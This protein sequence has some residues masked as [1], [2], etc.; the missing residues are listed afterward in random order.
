[1]V[2]GPSQENDFA[3]HSSETASGGNGDG[4]KELIL[5]DDHSTNLIQNRRILDPTEIVNEDR[6]VGRS[7]QLKTVTQA[8]RVVIQNEPPRN[9]YLYGPSGTG[10]SLIL[11]AVCKNIDELCASRDIRFGVLS[12][13][14]QNVGTLSTVVYELILKVAEDTG[15]TIEIPE[16]GIPTKKKWRELYRLINENYDSVV[17][18]LDELDLL[19]GRRDIDEPAFSRLLYQLSRTGSSDEVETDVTVAAITNDTTMLDDVGSRA[20]ST[21]SPEE[22]HFSDYN[23]VQLREILHNRRDA[24]YDGVLDDDVIP[25]AAAFSAQTH[26]DARKAIDL[27]RTAGSLAERA[28]DETVQEAHVR[29][30]QEKVEKNRVLEVTRGISTQKK[31]CLLATAAVAKQTESGT[32]R[33]THGYTIYQWL[34][35]TLDSDQYLQETYVNKM[36][37]LTTYSLVEFE[38]KSGGPRSGSYLEFEFAENPDRV[39]ET[40]MEDSRFAAVNLEELKQVVD[41][42]LDDRRR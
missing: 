21:F 6:I 38:R 17:F 3:D 33:S 18:V 15:A 30:A 22:I 35:E 26:G 36:K 23:A 39:I 34:T 28:G 41:A 1:M 37:E 32:A 19:T 2:D 27:F 24:F 4:I 31:L 11:K 29:Q 42:Q 5:E 7:N 12:L 14:C 20:L 16:H 9:L 40:L 10:K 13:N 25:L 8:L